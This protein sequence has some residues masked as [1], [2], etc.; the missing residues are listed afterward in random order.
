[1]DAAA[2]V[3]AL[4]EALA[5]A[6][7]AVIALDDA[8]AANV[9]SA[10]EAAVAA[11]A[12]ELAAAEAAVAAA[13][14]ELAAAE[15]EVAAAGIALDEALA[16]AAAAVVAEPAN[17]ESADALE[18]SMGWSGTLDKISVYASGVDHAILES[19]AGYEADASGISLFREILESEE[20]EVI[21]ASMPL[22]DLDTFI[23]TLITDPSVSMLL[24]MNANPEEIADQ[25]ILKPL[26]DISGIEFSA[27][28]VFITKQFSTVPQTEYEFD[29]NRYEINA[30]D[31]TDSATV[32]LELFSNEPSADFIT[33]PV[34]EQSDV[35]GLRILDDHLKI[36]TSIYEDQSVIFPDEDQSVIFPDTVIT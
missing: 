15:A 20:V 25:L 18:A 17:V 23:S 14:T 6:A 33:F 27:E 5:D 1:M 8:E 16:E 21:E 13:A 3:N 24:S 34:E 22:T 12:T 11:A 30:D 7:A 9:G 28:D 19:N 4:D 31:G 2:A 29:L 10:E 36:V 35:S 26:E 32:Y